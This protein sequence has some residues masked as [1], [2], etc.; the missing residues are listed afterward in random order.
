MFEIDAAKSRIIELV[1]PL[2]EARQLEQPSG[3]VKDQPIFTFLDSGECDFPPQDHPV[4]SDR[5][6][7]SKPLARPSDDEASED[8]DIVNSPG[9]GKDYV[10]GNSRT[11][12][13]VPDRGEPYFGGLFQGG[14]IEQTENQF[15]YSGDGTFV[16]DNNPYGYNVEE[17][18]S[19]NRGEEGRARF[20]DDFDAYY[21]DDYI[22][23]DNYDGIGGDVDS[24]DPYGYGV[25][26][27]VSVALAQGDQQFETDST[28]HYDQQSTLDDG[29]V[30]KSGAMQF[31]PSVFNFMESFHVN[32]ALGEDENFEN[33]WGVDQ[34]NAKS[35]AL[36][37]DES[38]AQSLNFDDLKGP[39][40][41]D[42]TN[43]HLHQQQHDKPG[44]GA[45]DAGDTGKKKRVIKVKVVKKGPNDPS[46]QGPREDDHGK[47]RKRKVVKKMITPVPTTNEEAEA[48]ANSTGQSPRAQSPINERKKALHLRQAQKSPQ[49]PSKHFV[50]KL[51]G[52]LSRFNNS[53]G[54]N[55]DEEKFGE[56]TQSKGGKAPSQSPP[57]AASSS[58]ASEKRVVGPGLATSIGRYFSRNSR[59]HPV[60][61][62]VGSVGGGTGD[63]SINTNNS[64]GSRGS[65]SRFVGKKS[66]RAKH[67]LLGDDGSCS[68]DSG[69][70]ARR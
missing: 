33:A 37:F 42:E 55:H 26:D 53:G 14:A 46:T 64:R 10:D 57:P 31:N 45:S 1:D 28:S 34:V 11:D 32:S 51:Y 49:T 21:D 25:G 69:S 27:P 29:F 43:D 56:V 67:Q 9:I 8:D 24:S 30:P 36:A 18:F 66:N 7:G 6:C 44:Q 3:H 22:Y 12:F 48:G 4:S 47:P 13:T 41:V 59:N 20:D 19:S 40:G 2:Q 35:S 23:E 17:T 58:S 68:F 70:L 50:S 54:I 63:A 39:S 65:L 61:A 38:F 15:G 60:S 52:S 62:S 16:D 5:L